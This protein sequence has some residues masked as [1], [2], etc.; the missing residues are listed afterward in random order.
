MKN[1]LNPCHENRKKQEGIQ[2]YLRQVVC[3][4]LVAMHRNDLAMIWLDETEI[5]EYT[6][7]GRIF[8]FPN[9]AMKVKVS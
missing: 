7:G 5:V 3:S 2:C 6:N 1:G 8:S 9:N 4:P